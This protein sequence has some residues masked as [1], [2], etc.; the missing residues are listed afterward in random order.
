M[1]VASLWLGGISSV[2]HIISIRVWSWDASPL[3][4]FF[5][6]SVGFHQL[7]L[8]CYFSFFS[9]HY[10]TVQVLVVLQ[11]W[12]WLDFGW[13]RQVSFTN[14]N[15]PVQEVLK[16][17]FPSCIDGICVFEEDISILCFQGVKSSGAWPMDSLK[18]HSPW[19]SWVSD[20]IL[21]HVPCPSTICF[22]MSQILLCTSALASGWTH[23]LVKEVVSFC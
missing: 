23:F 20:T 19:V 13:W 16:V 15:V 8:L 22:Y 4:P 9:W 12:F 2:I 10:W 7:Q 18:G 11:D 6:T 3:V 1:I 17:F 14:I 5:K 21:S